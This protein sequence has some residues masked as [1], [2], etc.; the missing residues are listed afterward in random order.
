MMT[1]SRL[2]SLILT[3]IYLAGP[4]IIVSEL[5]R[6]ELSIPIL[7]AAG[8]WM[9]S[10][11]TRREEERAR[12]S[13]LD[14][15]AM[16]CAFL[17]C[18]AWIYLSGIGSFAL[19]RWD[20]IK[21]NVLFSALIE[22]YLPI[23]TQLRGKPYILH[24][25]L[26]YYITP[27]RLTEFMDYIGLTITLN[28][29]LILFYSTTLLLSLYIIAKSKAHFLIGLLL[30]MALTGGLDVVGFLIFG[31]KPEMA[32]PVPFF[33]IAI[34]RSLEWW[35]WP[36]APQSLT[37]NLYWAPQHFFAAL[38]GTALIY[39]IFRS[40]R[41]VGVILIE[42]QIIVAACVFWSAYAAVGLAVVALV[43]LGIE[44][45]P[46]LLPRLKE[47]HLSALRSLSGFSAFA[48]AVSL[49]GA[50]WLFAT[51]ARSLSPPRSLLTEENVGVWVLTY[52]INYA[53][54]LLSLVLLRC[55]RAWEQAQP[56]SAEARRKLFWTL[57]ALLVASAALLTVH[58]GIFNDWA[59]RTTLPLS[60]ALAVVLTQV[61]F[62]GLRQ[63]YL[64]LL[65]AVLIFSS[66]A[67]L[68]EFLQSKVQMT[69]ETS[70]W[71]PGSTTPCAPYGSYRL[72]NLGRIAPQYSG[73]P[74]SALYQYFVRS[75]DR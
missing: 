5:F 9:V 4:L 37:S 73:R 28:L 33:G 10:L 38:I 42:A 15:I 70:P 45:Y 51:A 67:S 29:T 60:I 41:P 32:I 69:G 24:Y 72:E 44:G 21:H 59:M 12:I 27:V 13:T 53:P 46:T 55:P 6:P 62:G 52:G 39:S 22:N 43:K 8:L 31:T 30:V 18:V 40:E 7:F 48:C 49:S 19:C 50:A 71:L 58:H 64:W 14:P 23:V 57:S 63:Q 66:A 35:G 11:A 20:Y 61:L 25:S 3:I 16:T 47:E 54:L 74:H 34:P 36:N 26:A 56:T 75:P 1:G 65:L 17:L 2:S 68:M